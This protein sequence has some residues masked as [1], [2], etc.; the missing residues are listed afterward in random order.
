MLDLYFNPEYAKIYENIDGKS[1]TFYFECEYGKIQNTFIKREVELEGE[2][3]CEIVTPY[4]YGGPIITECG[5]AAALMKKYYEAFRAYCMENNVICEFIRFHLFDNTDVRE[6]YYGD[7]VHMSNNVVVNTQGEFDD[8]WMSY[9]QKVRKNVKKAVRNE[10]EILIEN[11]TD[12]LDDFLKIYY[13]TMDRNDAKSYYYF[14]KDYFELISEKLPENYLYFYVLKDNKVISTELV[15][16]SEKYAYSFLGGT[17]SEYYDLRPNDYLKNEIIK[18]CNS[19]GRKCFILGGG[20]HEN[21]G[22]YRYKRS[23]TKDE[24]VKF[25]SGKHIFNTDIYNK[26]VLKRKQQS[27]D[28]NDKS[29]YFPLYRA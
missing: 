5:D 19:T 23:F 12:H 1:D 7:V 16:C 15:L 9:E 13:D 18:W 21:D 20:Y 6:N 27:E 24:D 22:I 29:E 25:Y 14:K 28:F 26:L 3:Y 2:K 8:I 17:F 4:G 10:L 11:S